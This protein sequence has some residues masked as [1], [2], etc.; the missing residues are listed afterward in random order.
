MPVLR[1]IY[2][3]FEEYFC[4]FALSVMIACLAVQVFVR[5]AF[6]SGIAWAE[7]LSRFSFIWA[8]YIGA[9]L[10][11]KKAAHVRISAQFLL[12][13][14]KVR[15]FFRI[16]ADIIWMGFNLFFVIHSA[17]MVSE[18]FQYPEVSPTLG[19]TKAYVE[20]IIP[21]SFALVTFRTVELYIT[22]WRK[23]TLMELVSSLMED[24]A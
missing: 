7:E 24:N 8:V 18:A 2:D 11:A 4:A 19:W 23:G 12:A 20:M 21:I 10:G 15:L 3:N 14:L 1:K 6:G 16:L 22:R 5:V 17:G 9:S 13:P